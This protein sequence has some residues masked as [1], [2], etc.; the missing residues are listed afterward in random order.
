MQAH[1]VVLDQP[2]ALS[3]RRLPLTDPGPGDVVVDMLWSGISSGTE[4]LLWSGEMPP[5][6]GLAYP[7]VPGYESVGEIVSAP[8]GSG[9]DIGQRVFV[10]G[11]DCY[12][13]VRGLFGG[14]ASRVVI[15]AEKAV[16]VPRDLGAEAVLLALAA[17]AHHALETAA[18]LP[19]LI[20]GH[21]VLGR[22]LARLTLLKGGAPVVWETNPTRR[23]APYPVISPEDDPRRDYRAICDVSG[24]AGILDSLIHR[25][26]KGGEI[27]LAGFYAERLSFA[28]PM[29]FIREAKLSVAAEWSAADMAA[30][31]RL[32]AEGTLALDGLLTHTAQIGRA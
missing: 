17:T 8:D 21:G 28:F 23:S 6:P 20:I 30:V 29:A 18:A 13:E 22:L 32:A 9:L 12:G 19:E 14:T 1:A 15:P 10:P 11:A 26:A 24:D 16:P 7:L 25:L 31:T 4:R 3:M 5:F 2:K 27:L